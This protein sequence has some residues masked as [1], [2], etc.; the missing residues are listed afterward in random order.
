[1]ARSTSSGDDA[2]VFFPFREPEEIQR[3]MK[4]LKQIV[5]DGIPTTILC[6]NAGQGRAARRAPER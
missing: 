2:Q 1:M 6:D 4:R 3:D 5:A